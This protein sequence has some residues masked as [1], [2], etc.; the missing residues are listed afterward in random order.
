V[1]DLT[2]FSKAIGADQDTARIAIYLVFQIND[3]IEGC[4]F[5]ID[6]GIVRMIN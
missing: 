5:I 2:Y 6:R 4:I 1:G 3:Y